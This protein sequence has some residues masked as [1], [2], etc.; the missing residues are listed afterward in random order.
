MA[1]LP[2]KHA[3]HFEAVKIAM[4][5][6]KDGWK[7]ILAV[8]PNDAPEEVLRALVG[9][10]YMIAAVELDEHEQPK[11]L[12]SDAEKDVRYAG[13]LCRTPAFATWMWSRGWAQEMTEASAADGLRLVLGI[14]SRS[15][16]ATN[17][18]VRRRF[19]ELAQSYLDDS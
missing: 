19:R 2:S 6:T 15:E 14:A 17:E 3:V 1:D 4:N 9:A 18:D 7:L 8:H 5:Q 13:Q 16:I 12:L 11:P 10:R